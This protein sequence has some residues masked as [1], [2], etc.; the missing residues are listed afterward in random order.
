MLTCGIGQSDP[1]SHAH[2]QKLRKSFSPAFAK[3]KLE[4]NWTKDI[5]QEV[6]NFVA[7]MSK[8][9]QDG[10]LVRLNDELNNVT[11]DIILRVALSVS[12]VDFRNKVLEVLNSASFTGSR[13]IR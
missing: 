4:R 7:V 3:G 11:V 2:W 13:S 8:S 10:S 6:Q 1:K 12:N 9:A 5:V